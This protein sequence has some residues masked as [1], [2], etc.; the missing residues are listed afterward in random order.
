MVNMSEIIPQEIIE[1]KIFLIRGHKVMLDKDLATLYGVTTGNLNKAVSRNIDRFPDDFM[2]QLTDE[3]FKNLIFQ[4]GISSWG[5][6][7]K[8]S[9]V[10]TEQGIAML[11]S[12]LKSKRAIHVNIAIMRVFVKLKEILSTHKELSGKLTELEN[13]IERHDE[14]IHTIF[15][16]IRQLMKPP[17]TNKQ[18]I[19]F[20]RDTD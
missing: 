3:E 6:T 4:F 18:K 19:G 13:K 15:E 20:L 9:R 1:K 8:L 11:S 2:I 12:V 16:A 10:F 14:E 17:D 5:G 7:R